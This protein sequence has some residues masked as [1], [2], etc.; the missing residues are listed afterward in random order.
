[1][2]GP[3]GS[4][5][6]GTGSKANVYTPVG[7]GTADFNFQQL[8]Q[9]M[10]DS[11][12]A[13]S[14]NIGNPAATNYP[15][16]QAYVNQFLTGSPYTADAMAG[17]QNAGNYGTGTLAPMGEANAGALSGAGNTALN[18]GQ[19]PTYGSAISM[20]QNNPFYAGAQTGANTAAQ[21]G[22]QGGAAM[23]GAANQI[24]GAGFDPQSALF[25][26]T[27]Q[28]T[29]DAAQAA[30]AASGIGSTPYGASVAANALGN[31][32]INWQNQQLGRETQ[33]AGAASPLYQAAPQLTASSAAA[34]NA[35]YTNQIGQVL[36]ALNSRNQ[37]ANAGAA[38]GGS[39]L[40]G[41]QNLGGTAAQQGATL[42]GLPYS[43]GVNFANNALSG[44]GSETNLGNN[45]YWLPQQSINDL[46]S[47]LG[48]GQS[49]SSL[50]GSL[51][52]LGVN[53]L[54]SGIGGG[55]AG[56]NALVGN[57][58]LLTGAGGLGSLLGTAGTGVADSAPLAAGAAGEIGAD[59]G[60]G[61][62][63]SGLLGALPFAGS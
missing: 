41:A 49:A 57:N 40:T 17:A 10:I 44:L 11:G 58:G 52:Q 29:M 50:S 62:L 27:Q 22:Q 43:T 26:R 59:F 39:A 25:N 16:A 33:A 47:Y 12:I 53:Q 63:G 4:S 51:G 21:Q 13:G 19:D 5:G 24:M 35:A 31:F 36:Q 23:Q 38:A 61:G 55:L 15:T 30:N 56:A 3:S 9:P 1:M 42:A 48:L 34:P 2:S 60:G 8:I 54:A 14:T 6:T 46:E 28:Q 37:A 45:A 7:Q 32:G 20:L 18:Y